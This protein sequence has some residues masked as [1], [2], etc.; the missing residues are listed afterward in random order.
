MKANGPGNPPGDLRSDL[1]RLGQEVLEM[2]RS[3]QGRYADVKALNQIM[4]QVNAGLLPDQVMGT[5]YATMRPIIPYQRICLL[6]LDTE[7]GGEGQA[8]AEWLGDDFE[9]ALPETPVCVDLMSAEMQRLLKEGRTLT[10]SE[11]A[12]LG[13][14]CAQGSLYRLMCEG[15]MHSA[16]VCPLVA[17]GRPVGLLVLSH[18]HH[19]AYTQNHANLLDQIS[20]QLATVIEKSRLYRQ[21][22]KLNELKNRFLGI[23]AHDLRNPIGVIKGY[24]DLLS[25]EM[26]GPLNREQMGFV[27]LMKE[28]AGGMLNMIND[29]LDVSAIESGRLDLRWRELELCDYLTRLAANQRLLAEAKGIRLELLIPEEPV[30]A[31]LDPERIE[32]VLTNL[33]NNAIKFS[34]P[35]TTITLSLSVEGGRLV[36]SVSDQGRG[37]PR[38]E[39]P[40]LF[41]EFSRTSTTPTAGEKSTGLGLAIVK[42]MVSAHG[43]Y[44]DVSSVVGMGSLFI[45]NL[46]LRHKPPASAA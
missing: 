46:P 17:L 12:Q 2:S 21:L 6:T 34:D 42:R 11:I 35:H 16:L 20:G 3:L 5:I 29:L 36:L 10:F 22:V 4:E 38:D 28:T 7:H 27:A 43:G 13:N 39:L 18:R 1:T 25:L 40:K 44:V 8:C 37:I 9:M 32:Q 15:G 26:V 30:H 41:E 45:V 19:G 24:L 14:L 23:A 31:W 33:I